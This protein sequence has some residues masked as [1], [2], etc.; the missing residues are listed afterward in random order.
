MTHSGSLLPV[1]DLSVLRRRRSAKWRTYDDDVLPL[2]VAEMDF[3][4]APPVRAALAQAVER[5]DTGYGC[6]TA[7]L[8]A[9]LAKFAAERWDWHI[10]PGGVALATDV[11][12]ACVELLRALCRPGDRVVI[13]PPVYPPF[14]HWVEE[15]E[16]ALVEA[17]LRHTDDGSWRLDLDALSDAFALRP[18]V[19]VLCNPQNPVG[20]AHSREELAE[21]VRL[22]HDYDVTVVS[23]EIHGPL[24]LPGATFTPF[25]SLPGAAEIGLSLASASKAWN[26]A[27][28]KCAA[29]VWAS[30]A[31]RDVV[32]RRPVD[33][34]WRIGHFGQIASVAAYESGGAWLDDLLTT[35]AARRDLLRH[36]LAERLPD[37]RWSPPE[38]TFLAWLDCR[39]FGAGSAPCELFLERG[40][41]AL[42]AG[43]EFG[44]SGDG[45]VRLNFA[46]SEQILDEAVRRM[47]A[48][49][50]TAT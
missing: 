32:A 9:A 18:S 17:P 33:A 1:E 45:W 27:G 46:T 39:A 41:V 28:L 6:G 37:V 16:C 5:S 38:A 43:P 42:D 19:F 7:E 15:A 2:P 25:L 48:A 23:D 20:R 3:A 22:A 40:R 8:G 13:C 21:V 50:G 26:L 4:L 29:I 11:G 36:L 12:V 30:D 47:A 24:A 14:F 10:D 31:M 35:L 44:A 34:R 49:V